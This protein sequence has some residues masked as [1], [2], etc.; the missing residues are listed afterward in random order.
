[1]SVALRILAAGPGVTLQDGGRHGYLR[2]GVTAAGPMDPLAFAT[3]NKAAGASGAATAIEVSL[4]GVEL[5]AEDGNVSV[6]IA[7]GAFKVALDGRDIPTPCVVRLTSESRL[8]IRAGADGGCCYGAPPGRI[9]V[10]PVLGSVSTHTRSGLGGIDGRALTAGD[11]LPITSPRAFDDPIATIVAPWLERPGDEIRVLLGP[12]DDYFSAGEIAAFL[13]GPWTLASRSDRMA[14]QLEGPK[15]THAKGF[16]IISDGIAFGGIQVPGSGQPIVLMADR[17]P[18]G[19]YPKIANVIG[20]DLGRLAQLRPGAK[21][22][23]RAVSVEEAVAAR[24]A[25]V[26]AL[27]APLAREPLVRA[28][29]PSEFLLGLNLVGG[30]T[31]GEGGDR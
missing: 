25:E 15:L 29:L 27:A 12:Q 8:S 16:N 7:G 28:D 24:R 26:A 19:G 3:A 20:A 18:T 5:S 23:F 17:Q 13:D 1:V 14:Y 10:P 30:V 6:A 21:F 4:G 31:A 9:D 11:V 2:F 22:R